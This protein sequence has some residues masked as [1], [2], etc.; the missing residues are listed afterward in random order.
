MPKD[1]GKLDR[2]IKAVR[3]QQLELAKGE[4]LLRQ[5][6]KLKLIVTMDQE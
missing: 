1:I 3:S 5:E 4:R 2:E 6:N